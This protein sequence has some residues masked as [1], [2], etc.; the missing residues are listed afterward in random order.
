MTKSIL[1]FAYEIN[2]LTAKNLLQKRAGF[3]AKFKRFKALEIVD[4]V[5]TCWNELES[6][7]VSHDIETAD[8]ILYTIGLLDPLRI[9]KHRNDIV[10]NSFLMAVISDDSRFGRNAID[11]ARFYQYSDNSDFEKKQFSI[12]LDELK[13]QY[14]S[15]EVGIFGWVE[16]PTETL[17][18]ILKQIAVKFSKENDG[19]LHFIEITSDGK[20]YPNFSSVKTQKFEGK[21][22]GNYSITLSQSDYEKG[23]ARLNAITNTVVSKSVVTSIS[24]KSSNQEKIIGLSEKGDE[25]ENSTEESGR[26]TYTDDFKRQVA[27]AASQEGATLA[28]VGE[29]YEVSPTLVRNWKNK[30]LEEVIDTKTLATSEEKAESFSVKDIQKWLQSSETEGIIDSEGD[31]SVSV[32]SSEETITDNPINLY[33][34]GSHTLICGA[35]S[36]KFEFETEVRTNET[37]YLDQII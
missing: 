34:N 33:L 21:L 27:N 10:N 1:L 19:E 35:K 37:N 14:A 17:D 20:I 7:F 22:A 13:Y 6:L 18:K 16:I 12:F 5:S 8:K 30:F 15:Q 23:L 36:E 29:Q 28:S 25:T 24:D 9:G 11:G 4:H 3:G 31:L 32:E 2:A 26:K